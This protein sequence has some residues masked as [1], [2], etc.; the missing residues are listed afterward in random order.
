MLKEEGYIPEP[1]A[2]DASFQNGVA[3][4]PNRTLADMMRS[5]LH[6]AQL[7]PEYWSW[8]ILH[9]LYLKN[10]LPHRAISK[11][12]YEAYTGHR[13][14]LKHLHIFGSP[15][16]VRH[17]GRR[18]AKLDQHASQGIFLGYTATHKNVY[19]L[20]SGTK[21]IKIGRHVVFDAVGFTL[22]PNQCTPLQQ[23]L[24]LHQSKSDTS[25]LTP[26]EQDTYQDALDNTMHSTLPQEDPE[27]M[28]FHRLT[29]AATIP[30]RATPDSAGYDLHSTQE[31]TL[32]PNTTTKVPTD[33]AVRPPANTYCQLLSRSGL[34]FKHG[35]EVR[36]GT[37]DRDY[38]GN[39]VV[40]LRNTSD[41]P[42]I[43][44]HGDRIAQLVVY[45][46]VHP[47]LQECNSLTDTARG[48]G[49]FGSTGQH[50]LVNQIQNKSTDTSSDHTP[51]VPPVT[52]IVAPYNIWLSEHPFHKLLTID[53]ETK[54]SHPTMGMVLTTTHHKDRIQ[55]VDMAKS[56]PAAKIPH[57]RSTLKCA[58]LLKV[59]RHPVTNEEQVKSA[60]QELCAQN[61]QKTTL[62][63]ATVQHHGFHPT[64]GS[65]MLYYDQLNIIG[66]HL[67]AAYPPRQSTNNTPRVMQT[68]GEPPPAPNIPSSV[69]PKLPPLA[70]EL[71]QFFTLKQLKKRPD[72]HL[73]R[74]AWYKM[75]DSYHDQRMFSDPMP[76]PND[77][78]IH[79]MLW[80]YTIK[81]CGTRK[82][83][84][85]CDGSARQGTITLG[86]TFGNSLDAP[87]ERL[88]WAIVAKKGL[89]AFGADCSNAFAEAPP[90]KHHTATGGKIISN[91]HPSHQNILLSEFTMQFK[92]TRNHPDC[93]KS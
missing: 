30:T 91:D 12:P 37:I 80:R 24:Q 83:R 75:L 11:T 22:P 43:V 66:Q 52:E 56:T 74:K 9:A 21:Q 64:E 4:R 5:L 8:A 93:G 79:H 40:L 42:Y 72:W 82:A 39:V 46:I 10:R 35:I 25:L 33:I 54:G 86:H 68:V 36:A 31:I 78:N 13:P 32:Q 17:P 55:L 85:V 6:S 58:I 48:S 92:D 63:F 3:E 19:Y 69:D 77:C 65:L 14:N 73:W 57:W 50:S 51:D 60:V 88:F 1:T 53:M 27:S 2:S 76:A 59:G 7:G 20:D 45:S 67:R 23:Q 34:V 81:M 71:G 49:G 18:P 47:T 44:R 70:S 87:S 26:Q 62:T 61:Q 84:M 29:P 90:P 89:T 28:Y 15:L 16:T 41:T 38:T